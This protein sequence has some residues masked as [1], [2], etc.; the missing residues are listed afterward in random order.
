MGWRKP[1]REKKGSRIVPVQTGTGTAVR[2]VSATGAINAIDLL[3][4]L[5]R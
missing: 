2:T 5:Y 3:L 4:L 1:E